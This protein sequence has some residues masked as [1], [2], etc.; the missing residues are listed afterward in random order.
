MP[1]EAVVTALTA[2]T[3]EAPLVCRLLA[4]RGITATEEAQRF[5]NPSM[6]D[7]HSPWLMAD[8]DRAVERLTK[9]LT[10]GE[11]VLVYGDYDVDG[12]TAVALM[13]SALRQLPLPGANKVD[14]YIPDRY[15]EGY[16]ISPQSLEHAE[17]GGY[18]LM[19]ALDCGVKSLGP[20]TEARE[21]GIDF[22]VCDHHLPSEQLPP[23]VAVLDT[24]RADCQY[25]FQG[26]SGCGV[27]YKLVCALYE[28]LGRPDEELEQFLD[29]LAVSIASDIVPLLGENRILAH[30]GLLRLNTR[31]REGLRALMRASHVPDGQ[32]QIADL[33][34]KVGPRINA[35]GRMGSASDAVRLMLCDNQREATALA[36]D[37][38]QRNEQRKDLDRR[39]TRQALAAVEANAQWKNSTT[40]VLFEPSWSKGVVGI[41]ASRLAEAFM[42]PTVVLTQSPI[43]P[44]LAT[45]SARC[46]G[47]FDLYEAIEATRHLLTTYGGHTNAAGLTMPVENVQEF[48]RQ[49]EAQVA[50]ARAGKTD[51]DIL[52]IDM[53]LG[54][55]QLPT[56]E[57]LQPLAPFG[58]GNLRPLFAALG[59]YD[60]GTS[61]AVGRQGQHLKMDIV[62]A[63]TRTVVSG[64][65][66]NLGHKLPLLLSGEP[67]D[68]CFT[69]DNEGLSFKDIKKH[70]R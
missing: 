37:I 45:G 41:V 6:G 21:R 64:I 35:A 7:R 24:L 60:Y 50:Q 47:S 67:L 5:F 32:C 20:I 55:A 42:R 30:Y 17:A 26:L 29:L 33:V 28:A 44:H 62:D 59:V 69:I 19:V 51:N 63:Q 16:G 13:V 46:Q 1:N 38:E 14:Y 8:M 57:Q 4:Q 3:G 56:P 65:G 2:A 70:S 49:F 10:L 25:P 43:D 9:A 61:K 27:G 22:L 15:E 31:P 48:T 54:L 39:V 12:T 18:S 11:K 68:V 40:T 58:P 53:E 52:D 66:Y 36:R 34:F 23:A